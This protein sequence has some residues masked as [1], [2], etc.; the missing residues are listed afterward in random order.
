MIP[1][2]ISIVGTV[3]LLLD[4]WAIISVLMGSSGVLRKIFWIVIILLL[5]L[6]GMGLYFLL[7]RSS[8]DAGA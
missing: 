6:I 5:P 8:A 3:I 4:V 1:T 2:A 7:G